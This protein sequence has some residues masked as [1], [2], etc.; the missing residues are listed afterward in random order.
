[1]PLYVADYLA[2]TAHLSAA[3]HGAYLL[4]IMHYWTK[5]KLP[6]DEESM[7]RIT[8]LTSRQWSQSHDVLRS[9]F[10]DKWSHKR[11]DKELG[12]AIEKSSINS[13]NAKRRHFDR[14]SNAE[15]SDTQPQSQLP[16][17]ESPASAGGGKAYA[18]ESGYVRLVQRDFDRWKATYSHI[19]VAGE[20]EGLSEW[21]NTLG[22]DRWFHAAQKAL[23]NKNRAVKTQ[24]D[25]LAEQGGFRWNGQEGVI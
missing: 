4:L 8:R 10:G 23:A 22:K 25:Q 20:L 1:M 11:I 7:R 3:E 2:D 17:K 6:D 21:L 15:R 9:L 24:K 5:G 18:F 14:S 16:K 13:A 19:D 12:K